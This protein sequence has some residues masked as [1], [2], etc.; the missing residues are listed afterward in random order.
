MTGFPKQ[1][2]QQ[3][4]QQNDDYQVSLKDHDD[5]HDNEGTT[6]MGRSSSSTTETSK[7]TNYHCETETEDEEVKL[8]CMG[9]MKGYSATDDEDSYFDSSDEEM[10]Q[11]A[12]ASV[13]SSTSSQ[14]Q[15]QRPEN[16]VFV[17][18]Q[19]PRTNAICKPLAVANHPTSPAAAASD[20]QDQQQLS[21][22]PIVSKTSSSPQEPKEDSSSSDMPMSNVVDSNATIGDEPQIPRSKCPS[23]ENG[24]SKE[25][26][27]S[28][29]AHS[30]IG[31]TKNKPAPKFS[32]PGTT[33]E[34]SK[35]STTTTMVKPLDHP[36]VDHQKTNATK[37]DTYNN[38]VQQ[39]QQQPP[40]YSSSRRTSRSFLVTPCSSGV[41]SKGGHSTTSTSMMISPSTPS[42]KRTFSSAGLGQRQKQLESPTCA[43]DSPKRRRRSLFPMEN[44]NNSSNNDTSSNS[45]IPLMSFSLGPSAYCHEIDISGKAF[46][47]DATGQSMTPSYYLLDNMNIREEEEFLLLDEELQEGEKV[48][49]AAAAAEA[50][51][52]GSPPMS[53]SPE[54]SCCACCAITDNRIGS[55]SSSA[56]AAALV[57]LISPPPS[58]L[59]V[60]NEEDG[61]AV[62]LCEWPYNLA[63]DNALLLTATTAM[64]TLDNE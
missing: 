24:I 19:I 2:Q 32:S 28:S 34:T 57:P 1:Q 56:A 14:Q 47:A 50:A 51:A 62:T 9:G 10:E 5:R 64:T 58:P 23:N 31:T 22:P 40:Q 59:R 16:Q 21:P 45:N 49:A 42:M 3:Q 30:D 55:F 63:V 17:S 54:Q 39:Q 15:Q 41:V 52:N 6:T 29:S 44:G 36:Q 8:N 53:I 27:L 61:T 18:S 12:T 48:L 11:D 43:F 33:L 20:N 35:A 13:S 37:S 38:K 46:G 4:Q 60:E 25:L 26:A 7:L